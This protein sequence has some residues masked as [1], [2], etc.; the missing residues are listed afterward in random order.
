MVRNNPVQYAALVVFV[1]NVVLMM[2]LI[3][4]KSTHRARDLNALTRRSEY[5]RLLSR[6]IAFENCTDPITPAMLSDPAFID[7]LLEV[8]NALSGEQ[9][10]SIRGI[11]DRRE[12]TTH[13]VARL[14]SR[15]P[16][17]RRLRSAVILAELGDTSSVDALMEHLDDREPEI[18]I[19]AARGLARM[20]WTPA[21]EALVTRFGGETPWVRTRFAD[22]L[23]AF[24]AGATWPLI[25]Y[26]RVNH[27]FDHEGPAA[28]IRALATIGD[29]QAAKPLM[30][31]LHET[32]NPEIKL[33]AIETL[34]SLG[35]PIAVPTLQAVAR[36]D[37]W[38]IRAKSMTALADIGDPHCLDVLSKS[39]NDREWWVRHNA[40][41]GLAHVR[42]GLD[43]LYDALVGEDRLAA[44]AAAEALADSGELAAARQRET[45]GNAHIRDRQL[46]TYMG[47]DR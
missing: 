19:Q 1:I 37:D 47:A 4:L 38:R 40:A 26:I 9:G 41:E 23:A 27:E 46:L 42:G 29:D 8:R 20:K 15:F 11:I 32:T 22:T 10:R 14:R 3:A 6:H 36:S 7:A 33:A 30:E 13:Q 17:G 31:I 2:G 5:R 35:S 18:R 34:G 24:G 43:R 28:A 25:A 21:V 39:L 12:V 16:L 44:D 45:S